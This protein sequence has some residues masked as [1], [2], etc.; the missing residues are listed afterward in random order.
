M[1]I[2][3][4]FFRELS[5]KLMKNRIRQK[6]QLNT[7]QDINGTCLEYANITRSLHHLYLYLPNTKKKT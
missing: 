4:R 1:Q 7:I 3:P 5:G 2:S 6:L